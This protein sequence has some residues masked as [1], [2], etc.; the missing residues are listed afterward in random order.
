MGPSAVPQKPGAEACDHTKMRQRWGQALAGPA[1]VHAVLDAV[2]TAATEI[3]HLLLHLERFLTRQ[4]EDGRLVHDHSGSLDEALDDFGRAVLHA[5]HLGA[6]C[7]K[8][9]SQGRSAI[10]HVHGTRSPPATSE[11]LAHDTAT[12]PAPWADEPNHG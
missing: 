12:A 6:G 11:P 7:G 3:D 9:I 5:R 10:N 8:A 4:H 2:H 1:T